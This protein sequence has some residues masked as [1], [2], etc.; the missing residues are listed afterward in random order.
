M[1]QPLFSRFLDIIFPPQC[2]S[3][4]EMVGTHGTLCQP[5][6]QQISFISPPYCHACGLPFEYSIGEGTLCGDCLHSLPPFTHARS[7]LTYD[8]HSRGL[9]LKLKYADQTHLASIYGPWLARCGKELLEQADLIVPVPLH[10]WRFIT[11]RYNQSALLATSLHKQTGLPVIPDALLRKRPTKPQAGLTRKQRQDNVR[12]AFEVHKRWKDSIKGKHIV[13]V[14][15]VMT[16]SAT[17]NGCTKALLNAGA[18]DVYVLTLARAL[19]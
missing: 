5:C 2:L 13:L 1:L 8:E 7:A 4:E 18:A 19:D 9:I 3:C 10:Y 11:R 12:G 6:W 17:V 15:D 14:D 16:T